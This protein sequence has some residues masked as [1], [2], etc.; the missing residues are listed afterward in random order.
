MNVAIHVASNSTQPLTPLG[1]LKCKS[2]LMMIYT[3]TGSDVNLLV[4]IFLIKKSVFFTGK[5][6]NKMKINRVRF[7]FLCVKF[8]T[9]KVNIGI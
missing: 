2:I 8:F 5:K 3:I 4:N 7:T 9:E 6:G 1:S